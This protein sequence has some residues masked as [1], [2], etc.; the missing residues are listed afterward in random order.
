MQIEENFK[1]IYSDTPVPDIF[2]TEYLP[3]LSDR[4][5]K[6]YLYSLLVAR[7]KRVIP[8]SDV[9]ARMGTDREGIRVALTELASHGLVSLTD[10]GFVIEDVK[11][12][13]IARLYKPRTAALPSETEADAKQDGR[14]RMMADISKTFF[15]GLMSPSWYY[16]IENWFELYGFEPQVVYALFNECKRRR[17]LD[18][19]AYI[20]KVASNWAAHGIVTYEDLNRYSESFDRITALSRKVGQ[21]LRKN[22]TEYDEELIAGWAETMQYDFEVI[23]IALRKTSKLAN[24]NLEYAD[25]LLREWFSRQLK[26]AAE[27]TE[28][29]AGKNAAFARRPGAAGA[30][31]SRGAKG[32]VANFRQREYSGEYFESMLEDLSEYSGQAKG[33]GDPEKAGG[34]A[35]A[36]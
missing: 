29:E 12:I 16:E 5:V 6:L 28:Y 22:I 20:A 33:P 4:A 17:K 26:T 8:E 27:V 34:S 18:S 36:T 31:G 9:E 21:K 35:D 1:I 10:R 3:E 24:P 19:K 2:I 30:A 25:K 11:E 7:M 14:A 15:S 32:S 23:D 13:E